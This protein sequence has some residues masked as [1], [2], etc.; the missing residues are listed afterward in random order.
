[1]LSTPTS[2]ATAPVWHSGRLWPDRKRG[3]GTPVLLT[4]A[5]GAARDAGDE[6]AQM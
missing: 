2:G 6:A 4:A 5:G 3:R 1:M